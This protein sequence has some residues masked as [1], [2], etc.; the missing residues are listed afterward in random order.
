MYFPSTSP[1]CPFPLGCWC[2]GCGAHCQSSASFHST[3]SASTSAYRSLLQARCSHLVRLTIGPPG[4]LL[5][6]EAVVVSKGRTQ[7]NGN[8]RGACSSLSL[9][10]IATEL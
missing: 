6:D 7:P 1:H 5:Y 3:T 9:V 4:G 10:T 8:D 2:G